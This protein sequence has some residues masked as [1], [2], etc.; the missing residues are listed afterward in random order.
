MSAVFHRDLVAPVPRE[1]VAGDGVYL[2]DRDGRRYLDGSSGSGVSCLGHSNAA[3][4]AAMRRQIDTLAYAHTAFFTNAALEELSAHLTRDAGGL[5]HAWFTSSGAEA[6]EAALKLSRQYFLD[7]GQPEREIVIGRRGGYLGSSLAAL[8]AGGN[9]TRKAPFLPLLPGNARHI[10]PAFAYRG[11]RGGETTAEYARRTAGELEDEIQRIGPSRVAAFVVETVVGSTLGAVPAPD[12][13]FR[14]IRR[15]CDRHGVLLVLDEVMCGMGRAGTRFAFEQEGI[16]PDIVLLGKALAGGYA[17]LGAVVV[18]L[19][20]HAAIRTGTGFFRHGHSFHGHALACAAGLAVQRE[21][22]RLE[23]YPRI[24]Q[25][26]LALSALLHDA[27]A[28]H[29]HVGDIRGRGLMHGIE[30]VADRASK[31]IFDPARQVSARLSAHAMELGL[32]CYATGGSADGQVGDHVMLM[33]PFIA[34]P[35]HLEELVDK[36]ARALTRTFA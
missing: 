31:A 16:T 30:L 32:I 14:E 24:Q 2:I 8:S 34:E 19:A 29:P 10:G 25:A 3:V 22:E 11:L 20:I 6:T 4:R 15:I 36:L 26:G 21:I 9:A 12:G 7:I 1:A 18:S 17:P 27:F 23:L 28:D 13:Y 5:S 33:P 35:H